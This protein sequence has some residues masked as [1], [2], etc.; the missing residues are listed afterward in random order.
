MK[1]GDL[2]LDTIIDEMGIVVEKADMHDTCW[3][4]R[5]S[6][7]THVIT[8]ERDLKLIVSGSLI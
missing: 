4:V 6:D 8:C 7:D 1:I 2:V 3:V 5:L